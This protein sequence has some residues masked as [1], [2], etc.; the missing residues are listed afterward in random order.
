MAKSQLHTRVPKNTEREI[1][2]YQEQHDI[3]AES[4]AARQLIEAGVKAKGGATPGERLTE[5]ATGI[6]SA[7][8]LVGALAAV[9]G[10]SVGLSLVL[11]FLGSA[12]VFTLLWASIRTLG[13]SSLR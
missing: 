8:A 1:K 12:F 4:E 2:Q 3:E 10:S 9:T 13:G 7:G 11:P 6:S 5:T